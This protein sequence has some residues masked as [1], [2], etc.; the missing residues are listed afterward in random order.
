MASNYAHIAKRKNYVEAN[1]HLLSIDKRLK[2]VDINFSCSK[3]DLKIKAE[4]LASKNRHISDHSTTLENA[5][6][7]CSN[8]PRVYGLSLPNESTVEATINRLCCKRWWKR[9]LFTLQRQLI[10]SV[11]RDIGIVHQHSSPYS[12]VHSQIDRAQ[13]KIATQTYLE[14][15]YLINDQLQTYSLKELYEKSVSNPYIRRSELMVRIKGFELVAD[16]LG[17]IGEFYTITCPSRMHARYKKN[18]ISNPKYDGTN[19]RQAQV[20]L[21]QVWSRSRSQFARENIHV[22][23]FR[24]A[25]PNH[26]GTPHSHFL[27]FMQSIHKERVRQILKKYSLQDTPNEKG[28]KKSRFKAISI[29]KQKGSAAGYIAK[30]VAKNIDGSHI[31]TDLYGNDAG[32]SAKSIDTWA[33][34]W[35]IR[36]FQQIGG[37]SVT[38]W[39]ELRRIANSETLMDTCR[40]SLIGDAAIQAGASDFAAYVMTMGGPH[41]RRTERPI[42]I[43]YIEPEYVNKETGEFIAE[44]L[45]RYGDIAAAKIKGL[46]LDGTEYIT[47]LTKWHI[48]QHGLPAG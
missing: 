44:G 24:V 42:K 31:D 14:N 5:L 43:L 47:R 38:V 17:D 35:R 27:L 28:A 39:R 15:T 33:S 10:E 45:T 6:S 16:M 46:V 40:S 3:D 2:I 37:P 8:L 48:I 18:G 23:G 30:Y 34:T 13:Q 22:Y 1:L 25:E 7:Q 26:D 20:H 19:P 29:D 11:A 12:S 21:Q 32:Q 9:K 4:E 36:Q 41:M